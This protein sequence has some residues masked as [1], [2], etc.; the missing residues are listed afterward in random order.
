MVRRSAAIQPLFRSLKNTF[1]ND[2]RARGLLCPLH[3]TIGGPEHLT[4]IGHKPAVAAIDEIDVVQASVKL[5]R[6]HCAPDIRLRNGS[7]GTEYADEA[8][9][10]VTVHSSSLYDLFTVISSQLLFHDGMRW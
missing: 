6:D 2:L 4:G 3:A 9:Q 7:G 5:R 10:Y 8:E 1:R